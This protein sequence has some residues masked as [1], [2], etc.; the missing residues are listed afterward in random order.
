LSTFELLRLEFD[1]CCCSKSSSISVYIKF[2]ICKLV[3]YVSAYTWR[4]KLKFLISS[5]NCFSIVGNFCNSKIPLVVYNTL[6]TTIVANNITP[7]LASFFWDEV[8]DQHI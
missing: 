2:Q 5:S 4:K 6:H 3:V 1:W 8:R 7:S